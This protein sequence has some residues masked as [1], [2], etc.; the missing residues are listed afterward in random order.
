MKK[1]QRTRS[2][3]RLVEKA[4]FEGRLHED[5]GSRVLAPGTDIG[6]DPAVGNAAAVQQ[7][8]KAAPNTTIGEEVPLIPTA[9]MTAQLTTEMPPVED[10]EYVPASVPQLGI[11][12]QALANDMSVKEIQRLYQAVRKSLNRS[13]SENVVSEAP[14]D[15][16]IASYFA[17]MTDE[18]LYADMT[19][20]EIAKEKEEFE[21][22]MKKMRSD[23]GETY[24]WGDALTKK[25]PIRKIRGDEDEDKIGVVEPIEVT[26]G[27]NFEDLAKEL[28]LKGAS[29]AKQTVS[30]IARRLSAV[31]R[32]M[33]PKQLAGLQT[34]VTIQFIRGINPFVD[35]D[36]VDELKLNRN[37]TRGLDSYRFFFVNSFL[38][39]VYNKIYRQARK[40]I[41]GRLVRSGFPKRS[42][43]T[44]TNILFGETMTTPEKLKKKIEK[45]I[46]SEG[47]A[48]S[49]DEILDRLKG[50]YPSLKNLAQLS[51]VDIDALAR[52][53]WGELSDGRRQKEILSA[54][55]ETQAFQDEFN[56]KED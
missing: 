40:D 41:E 34:F 7:T 53:R 32:L 15:R 54:L 49:V 8:V 28:G 36:D 3:D 11:A 46:A 29:G 10:D 48:I 33:D 13:V 51:N 42:A 1:Q 12:I 47:S 38:L 45:D 19:P 37:V 23:A 39:P 50:L 55:E 2:L 24:T 25:D 17:D 26:S 27:M 43:S 31:E 4:L 18:E 16:N 44:V 56:E 21:A 35:E 30:R 9:E 22:T 20:E 52:A 14:R 6:H 5:L